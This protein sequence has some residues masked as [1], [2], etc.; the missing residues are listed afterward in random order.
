[1]GILKANDLCALEVIQRVHDNWLEYGKEKYHMEFLQL[2]GPPAKES[3]NPMKRKPHFAQ[4]GTVSRD[5]VDPADLVPALADELLYL[6]WRCRVPRG[7]RKDFTTLLRSC[8]DP[9]HHDDMYDNDHLNALITALDS[10]FA[11]PYAYFG[12]HPGD[13]TDYGFWPELDIDLP[14]LEDG[15][16]HPEYKGRDVLLVNDHG[17]VT[18]GR[19]DLRGKFHEYWSIV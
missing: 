1:M 11:P 18:C 14:R 3:T 6:M 9:W 10:T 17:N 2:I 7:A 5:T 4:L 19:Y 15:V 8:D 13:G 12:A 16:S